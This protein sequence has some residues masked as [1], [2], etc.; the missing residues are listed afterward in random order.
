M[1]GQAVPLP[2]LP[3]PEAG[4]WEVTFRPDPTIG[5]GTF[6][7]NGWLQELPKPQTK[8]TWDNVVFIRP[9]DAEKMGVHNG[10]LLKV[11][12]QR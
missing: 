6:A 9:S 7:N 1:N 5:D 10:N 12:R 4:D 8:T 3:A 2:A 11:S